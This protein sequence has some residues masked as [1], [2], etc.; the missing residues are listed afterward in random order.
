MDPLAKKYPQLTPYQFSS[1]TPIQAVDLDGLEMYYAPNGSLIGQ[2]GT[3]T[4]I[5]V[6]YKEDIDA[7]KMVV[8]QQGNN[9]PVSDGM[10]TALYDHGSASTFSNTD[11]AATDWGDKVNPQSIADNK[12]Y[13]SFIFTTKINDKLVVTYT[14]PVKG[15]ENSSGGVSSPSTIASIHSHGAY[16]EKYD[17][18]NFSTTGG[19]IDNYLNANQTGYLVTPNGSLQKCIPDKSNNSSSKAT[20]SCNMPSDPNDPNKCS[21]S[22]I[23]G[24][25]TNSSTSATSNL[26]DDFTN[27]SSDSNQ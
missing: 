6:V 23:P 13:S 27:P 24:M 22:N 7:A 17:N 2:Y 8:A 10:N 1:N 14:K 15:D 5:R 19:D 16:M 9:S 26:P 11:A 20:I 21:S 18:D 3:S 12:E 4:E 25:Q